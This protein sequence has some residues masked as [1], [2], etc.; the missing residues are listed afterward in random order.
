MLMIHEQKPIV[1]V[2]PV[3]PNQTLFH[4]IAALTHADMH[5]VFLQTQTYELPEVLTKGTV[6]HNEGIE[7]DL[8]GVVQAGDELFGV[9]RAKAT[10]RRQS[11]APT[12]KFILTRFARDGNRATII[13]T[14][15][16][17]DPMEVGRGYQQDAQLSDDVSRSHFRVGIHEGKLAIQDLDSTNGTKLITGR[18]TE[19]EA[20][21]PHSEHRFGLKA[22]RRRVASVKAPTANQIDPLANF[23][24]WAPKSADIKAV[25][26]NENVAEPKNSRNDHEHLDIKLPEDPLKFE[27]ELTDQFG[28]QF[29]ESAALMH[30][31]LDDLR[32]F[33]GFDIP[34]YQISPKGVHGDEVEGLN[35]ENGYLTSGGKQPIYSM[36]TLQ[37]PKK[38]R[39]KEEIA[40]MTDA[41]KAAADQTDDGAYVLGELPE[42]TKALLS[43]IYELTG[44][45]IIR[46]D[47]V[48]GEQT[49]TV[50][51]MGK[52]QGQ[53][54]FIAED[55]FDRCP[56]YG[57]K[58]LLSV[59]LLKQSLGESV[60][61]GLNDSQFREFSK[62][63]EASG[64]DRF[65]VRDFIADNRVTYRNYREI[66]DLLRQTSSVMKGAEKTALEDAI[67]DV[68]D[69][70]FRNLGVMVEGKEGTPRFDRS[71]LRLPRNIKLDK[72]NNLR[73]IDRRTRIHKAARRVGKMLKPGRNNRS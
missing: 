48:D 3:T 32:R 43:G 62:A 44:A 14:L 70:T 61:E 2:N 39:T 33:S 12:E 29:P 59:R 41:E 68:I 51:R 42:E 50:L 13:G 9:V 34:K 26:L 1:E 47:R 69:G 25:I 49:G 17:D 11:N 4:D 5:P 18:S 73:I 15:G 16:Q 65:K 28:R 64:M 55:Y 56:W 45:Q 36:L 21:Q 60:A 8:L 7:Q 71:L 23:E 58:D 10:D 66:A 54:I 38:A 37:M 31:A 19:K 53:D 22:L 72:D 24:L 35:D 67:G 63:A 52:Y 40:R 27:I 20:K 57:G 6:N 46:D 30:E